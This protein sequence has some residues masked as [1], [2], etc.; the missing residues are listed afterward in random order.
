MLKSEVIGFGVCV[1]V[2][3]FFFSVE[4]LI[5]RCFPLSVKSTP[6]K[7]RFYKMN[8]SPLSVCLVTFF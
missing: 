4:E 6:K 3:G 1:C 8:L 2:G 5:Q 7:K